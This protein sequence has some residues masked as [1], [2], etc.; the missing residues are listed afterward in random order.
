MAKLWP[1]LT[2]S[3]DNQREFHSAWNLENAFR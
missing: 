2:Q 1:E 3:A